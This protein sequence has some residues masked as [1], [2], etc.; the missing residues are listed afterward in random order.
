MSSYKLV[1]F[2]ETYVNPQGEEISIT[3][4]SCT[5][6]RWLG[7]LGY[8]YKNVRKDV[9]SD[10]HEQ[11]DVLKDRKNFLRKME[12]F[13]PYIIEFEKNG[14]MK[15]NIYPSNCAVYSNDRCPIIVITHDECTFF[16]NNRI[17][18]A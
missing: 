3:I 15:D 9:Y 11:S 17:R 2:L 7:R 10:G 16:A 18:K 4:R 6:Q 14:A 5:A 13:K 8:E 12:E 1:Q